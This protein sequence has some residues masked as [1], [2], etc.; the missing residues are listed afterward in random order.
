MKE[1]AGETVALIETRAGAPY[2]LLFRDVTVV[3][4]ITGELRPCSVAVRDGYIACVGEEQ[5]DADRAVEGRG[6]YLAPGIMDAR[7]HTGV[8][9]LDLP[10]SARA[11]LARGAP[12]VFADPHEIA[13]VLDPV[14][15][16]LLRVY[17]QL[18][19]SVPNAAGLEGRGGVLSVEQTAALLDDEGVVSLGE[20]PV[21]MF[22]DPD[23]NADLVAKIASAHARRK[24]INGHAP[25]VMLVTGVNDDHTCIS[26][27]DGVDKIRAG[28]RTWCRRSLS[29][30]TP[31]ARGCTCT[32]RSIRLKRIAF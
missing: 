10:E 22:L 21:S 1:A 24:S 25:A 29:G 30:R 9:M 2:D 12:A 19:S 8:T 26:L 28:W 14:G 27:A 20:A 16:L 11:V 32:W 31:K 6:R 4:V 18:P 15:E 7:I 5:V 13:N 3:D 23:R 17:V